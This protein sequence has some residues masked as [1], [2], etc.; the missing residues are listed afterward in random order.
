MRVL[1]APDKFKGSLTA[2]EAASAIAAGVR[3]VYPES[4][5]IELPIADGGEGTLEA[6]YRAGFEKR[7]TTVV[8]PIGGA[9]QRQRWTQARQKSSSPSADRP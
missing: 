5:V 3:R 7:L 2:N 4:T 1:V 8:G 6:A 9:H